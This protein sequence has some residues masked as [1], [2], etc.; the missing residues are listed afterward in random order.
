MTL[1]DLPYDSHRPIRVSTQVWI[2]PLTP[3]FLGIACQQCGEEKL[4][5]E[6]TW[7]RRP[8]LRSSMRSL[9]TMVA[10]RT[11]VMSLLRPHPYCQRGGVVMMPIDEMTLQEIE[12]ELRSYSP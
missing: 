8:V 9:Q 5:H 10:D 12:H 1:S 3:T 2:Y 6:E 4:H 7:A 11:A